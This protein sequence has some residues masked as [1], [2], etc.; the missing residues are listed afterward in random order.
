MAAYFGK[1]HDNVLRDIET[2]I[3]AEP[4]IALNF[5]GIEIDVKVGFV[6]A[7]STAGWNSKQPLHSP[8]RRHL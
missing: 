4:S 2:L 6:P 1:R 5:E 7:S 8:S 3:S